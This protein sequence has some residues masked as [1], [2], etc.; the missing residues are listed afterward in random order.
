MQWDFQT[1]QQRSISIFQALT[2]SQ[3]RQTSRIAIRPFVFSKG[4]STLID[5]NIKQFEMIYILQ[6]FKLI[7]NVSIL[8]LTKKL[9][10]SIILLNILNR[11]SQ[12]FAMQNYFFH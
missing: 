5:C 3:Q 9:A 10:Q 6:Y 2:T 8:D 12:L 11:S 4:N 1:I 7:I